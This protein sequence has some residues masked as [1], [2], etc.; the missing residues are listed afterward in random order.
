MYLTQRQFENMGGAEMDDVV[1]NRYAAHADAVIDRM[2][3]GRIKSEETV[4]A[5]VQY[6][7]FV[8]ITAMVSDGANNGR[9]ITSVSNDG[10]SVSYASGTAANPQQRY[11][12]IA[13]TYLENEEIDGVSILYAGVDD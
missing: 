12:N 6:A 9:E 2:T 1:Y 11:A 10:V 8:L 4:R 13:R 7:A 3:H 5:N